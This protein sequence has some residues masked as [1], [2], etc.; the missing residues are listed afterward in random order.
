MV[1]IPP[2]SPLNGQPFSVGAEISSKE[3]RLGPFIQLCQRGFLVSIWCFGFQT[4]GCGVQDVGFGPLPN[5]VRATSGTL[6]GA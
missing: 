1:V 3:M 4:V 5:F 2:A 6:A